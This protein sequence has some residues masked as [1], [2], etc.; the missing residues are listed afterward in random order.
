MKCLAVV[1][2]CVSI[3]K[4][5]DCIVIEGDAIPISLIS[6]NEP[7]SNQIENHNVV[8]RKKGFSVNY[9]DKG[10]CIQFAKKIKEDTALGNIPIGSEFIGVVEQV[11]KGV[12]M[13]KIGD[14]VISNHAYPDPGVA[15][16]PAGIPSN[17]SS[18]EFE[19]LHYGKL[20]KVPDSMSDE[21]AASFSLN[22]QTAYSMVR[23]ANVRPT[24]EILVTSA[25]SNTSLFIINALKSINKNIT[26][27]T[28]SES[29][30]ERLYQ[31]GVKKVILFDRQYPL[32]GEEQ[33]WMKS[34]SRF[35]IIFDPLF[36]I[37]FLDTVLRLKNGGRYLTCGS[38]NQFRPYGNDGSPDFRDILG[39]FVA[40]NISFIGNCLGA[41]SDLE[42]ALKSYSDGKYKI[43]LDSVY[44]VDD[45]PQFMNRSFNDRNRF[46]KV[47]FLY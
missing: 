28:S 44:G 24:D 21:I 34:Q 1:N 11:G 10:L 42:N 25:T 15:G 38:Y 35:D 23:K 17:H 26:A 13:F 29:A 6:C 12:D 18:L 41:T 39:Y 5:I 14:R 3:S 32:N 46:G 33:E 27:I 47:S 9:R 31:L 7:I 22:A 30:I 40:Q 4:K 43:I 8:V 45:I 19:T 16:A 37:Y 36:D 2:D 20:L